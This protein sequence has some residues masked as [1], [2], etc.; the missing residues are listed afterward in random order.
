MKKLRVPVQNIYVEDFSSLEND[1]ND[2]EFRS[3]IKAAVEKI[4]PLS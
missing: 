4:R 2:Q 3:R 1:I